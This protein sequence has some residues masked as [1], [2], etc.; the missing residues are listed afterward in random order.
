MSYWK[1]QTTNNSSKQ[2]KLLG[3]LKRQK[4]GLFYVKFSAEFHQLSL[5]FYK[6]QE[7]AKKWLKLK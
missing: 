3:I 2:Q 1:Q 7:V 4:L 5:F 6:Q